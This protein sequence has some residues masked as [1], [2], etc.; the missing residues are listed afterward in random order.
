MVKILGRGELKAKL[1][2][3]VKFT[4][5][6]KAAEAAGGTAETLY[7]FEGMK[8]FETLKMP[9]KLKSFVIESR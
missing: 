5:T 9:I 8:F 6:V 7:S 3:T 4:V 1:S 2:V